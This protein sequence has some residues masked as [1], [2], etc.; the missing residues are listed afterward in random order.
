MAWFPENQNIPKDTNTKINFENISQIYSKINSHPTVNCNDLT[1][2]IPFGCDS[3]D[4]IKNLGICLLNLIFNTNAKIHVAWSDTRF[5]LSK[6]G[7]NRNT[8]F[9]FLIELFEKNRIKFNS[10]SDDRFFYFFA[11]VFFRS[12]LF[13]YKLNNEYSLQ[14]SIHL[15]KSNKLTLNSNFDFEFINQWLLNQIKDRIVVNLSLRDDNKPF[16]R[17]K[18]LNQML[19]QVS[20]AVVVNH[21]ADILLPN[22][23]I[24]SSYTMIKDFKSDVVYPYGYST[25]NDTRKYNIRVFPDNF[26]TTYN[27]LLEASVTGDF[28]GINET[29]QVL[30]WSSAYGQSIFFNTQTYKNFGGENEEFVSWGA[31]DVERYVRFIKLGC[32]VSRIKHGNVYHLEHARGPDSGTGNAKFRNNEIL[33]ERI[34]LFD[35]KQLLSYYENC[36]Y[37]KKY[38]WRIKDSV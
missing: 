36:S 34:Q 9:N 21:D 11:D 26:G 6:L 7:I 29:G 2:I 19:D 1:F 13:R 38:N 16:H 5:H 24:S 32:L 17:T 8:E 35:K 14:E 15:I 28:T 18:Y 25:I 31:E 20:T 22:Q 12:H 4:R 37:L 23:T 33:W 27:S 3:E 30:K 10:L